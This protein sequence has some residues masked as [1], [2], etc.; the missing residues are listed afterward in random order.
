MSKP[1]MPVNGNRYPCLPPPKSCPVE[2]K[3]FHGFCQSALRWCG[4]KDKEADSGNRDRYLPENHG[5]G[6]MVK[7]LSQL[8][9]KA[10]NSKDFAIVETRR[11][12]EPELDL[13]ALRDIKHR[14]QIE[15]LSG[16]LFPVYYGEDEDYNMDD[17]GF[18]SRLVFGS[19]RRIGKKQKRKTQHV[20]KLGLGPLRLLNVSSG[21]LIAHRAI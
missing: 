20:S 10:L 19:T 6:D 17:I 18:N 16:R 7:H 9:I 4:V 2:W 13:V 5:V 3:R 1:R 11:Y 12:G 8:W 15:G 14:Q 21:Q